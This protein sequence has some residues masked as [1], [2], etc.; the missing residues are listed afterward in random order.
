MVL[1]PLN[2]PGGQTGR[3][4]PG[5]YVYWI[6]MAHPTQ[7]TLVAKP[8]MKTPADF[9][10]ESFTELVVNV[11]S[12]SGVELAEVACFFWSLTPMG[13]H[14]WPHCSALRQPAHNAEVAAPSTENAERTCPAC[15]S[16]LSIMHAARFCPSL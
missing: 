7:E 8:G 10:R 15:A 12:S 13:S 16:Q 11:H 2:G 3:R 5:Q 6:C 1:L 9:S 4:A 14:I